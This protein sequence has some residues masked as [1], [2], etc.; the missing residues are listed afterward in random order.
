MMDELTIKLVT[1]LYAIH[2]TK[3]PEMLYKHEQ[4]AALVDLRIFTPERFPTD[5]RL[6]R[7]RNSTTMAPQLALGCDHQLA[8]LAKAS[9]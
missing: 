3:T 5:F 1:E 7:R 2:D 4:Q 8:H 9:A 6:F